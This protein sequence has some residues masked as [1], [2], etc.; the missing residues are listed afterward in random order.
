MSLGIAKL[1]MERSVA[2]APRF[3]IIDEGFGPDDYH[4]LVII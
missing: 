2:N 4:R 1:I 3:L